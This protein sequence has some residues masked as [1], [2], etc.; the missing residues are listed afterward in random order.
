M[1]T[2]AQQSL[3]RKKTAGTKCTQILDSFAK[4]YASL[5]W[6]E[7]RDKYSSDTN[8]G[9]SKIGRT[10]ND[11]VVNGKLTA[12]ERNEVY[13]LY[14]IGV[15]VDGTLNEE[16]SACLLWDKYQLFHQKAL[17]EAEKKKAAADKAAAA[18]QNTDSSSSD[19]SIKLLK[20]SIQEIKNSLSK[21]IEKRKQAF[22]KEKGLSIDF[23]KYKLQHPEEFV[24]D[25]F[26]GL[27]QSLKKKYTA[28]VKDLLTK[29]GALE[30]K[31]KSLES[32]IQNILSDPEGTIKK[33]AEKLVNLKLDKLLDERIKKLLSASGLEAGTKGAIEAIKKA[34]R[35]FEYSI[36]GTEI[37]KKINELKNKA[38][39]SLSEKAQKLTQEK[40]D[41]LT[42]KVQGKINTALSK[43]DLTG[44]LDQAVSD[45][46]S[47]L[48]IE[49]L[50]AKNIGD[51]VDNALSGMNGK[52]KELGLDGILDTGVL[53]DSAIKEIGKLAEPLTSAKE[54]LLGEVSKQ[55]EEYKKIVEKYENMVQDTIKDLENKAVNFLKEQEQKLIQNLLSKVN[56]SFDGLGLS[57]GSFK[58]KF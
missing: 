30:E 9:L 20:T 24:N 45:L 56:I 15:S 3:L 40:L 12:S 8:L 38:L 54:Q 53:K 11:M 51:A 36:S 4:K 22:L 6:A 39:N 26:V 25:I 29:E 49:K 5:E 50:I 57:I 42:G 34:I 44:K 18:S 19:L 35:S 14:E 23:D 33:A 31:L 58:I 17:E 41:E 48:D 21:E 10:L 43:I 47:K 2:E 1:A 7:F 52:L 37:E 13:A 46:T 16:N 27:D 28:Y 55:I 32:K